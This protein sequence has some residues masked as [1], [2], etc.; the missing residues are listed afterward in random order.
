MGGVA[1]DDH[2]RVLHRDGHAIAGLFAAGATC[3]GLEGGPNASY[4]GGLVPAAVFGMLAARTAM[5]GT[6]HARS[7]RPVE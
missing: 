6:E 3:G 7:A 2:A 4:V 5:H 1:V